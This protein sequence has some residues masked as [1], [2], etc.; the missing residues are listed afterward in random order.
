MMHIH[1]RE[2]DNRISGEHSPGTITHK[3]KVFY[4]KPSLVYFPTLYAVFVLRSK[5]VNCK[6]TSN[7]INI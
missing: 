4:K 5:C 1:N 7:T 3:S 6:S 2:S